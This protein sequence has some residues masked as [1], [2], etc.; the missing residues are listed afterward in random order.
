LKKIDEAAKKI[1]LIQAANMS[2]GMNL[3]FEIVGQVAQKLGNEYDVEIVETH[4]RLKKDAPSGSS[5]TLAEKI[6]ARTNKKFPDCLDIGRKGKDALRKKGTI[7]IQA[8]R[9]G[10]TVG[11]HSVMFGT[12]GETVTISHSAHSR[13]TFATGAIRA[14]LWLIGKP[15]GRYSMAD[16]L[17]LK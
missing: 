6:A 17:G 12:V 4:H 7:G 9:L 5:L 16:V 13:D 15:A 8:I 11:E 10:D 14:A 3:L 1:P 2:V